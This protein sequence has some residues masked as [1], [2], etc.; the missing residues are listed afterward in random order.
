MHSAQFHI[1][2]MRLD[3][4]D[5]ALRWAEREGW[6]PGLE[7]A[8]C[9]Y[10]ADPQGFFIGLCDTEPVACVSAVRYGAEFGFMGFYIVAP[11]FR[12]RGYGG[13]LAQAGLQHLAGCTIGLDGVVAQQE[14]YRSAGFQWAYRNIRYRGTAI[15]TEGGNGGILP[16]TQVP[17]ALLKAYDRLLFPAPRDAFLRAWINQ[18]AATALG[19]MVGENLLG[20]GVIRQCCE[21]YKIG[22]L[23]ADTAVVAEQLLRALTAA[24]P[25][26]SH[27]YLDI[28]EP[29]ADA[30]A[31]VQRH[32]MEKV[33]ETA[34]MYLGE[35]PQLPL[36]RLY[37][38]TSFELG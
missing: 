12:G 17:F 32:G 26:G 14:N 5:V 15:L 11:Q 19:A 28:P 25:A 23:F 3:E 7:D 16:L 35:A 29:N 31:L 22:P 34:R 33:F 4:L 36:Q 21:G 9:F 6:D 24:V 18:S 38:V 2:N 37:G 10:A 13:K 27:F 8:R 1:R 30:C 20:Y